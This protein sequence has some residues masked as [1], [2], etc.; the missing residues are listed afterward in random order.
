M[1]TSALNCILLVVT[2]VYVC[3]AHSHKE[4][5]TEFPEE[6]HVPQSLNAE[7]QTDDLKQMLPE[8]ATFSSSIL[9]DENELLTEGQDEGEDEIEANDQEWLLEK[10]LN[11]ELNTEG[12][13]EDENTIDANEQEWLL[14]KEL[15]DMLAAKEE[16]VN[17][18][19]SESM[20]DLNDSYF[21][22]Q[23]DIEENGG[24][25]D[26]L[27]SKVL[28]DAELLTEIEKDGS[29]CKSHNDIIKEKRKVLYNYLF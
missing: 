1:A 28:R 15:N 6:G 4:V 21:G 27:S 10:E 18:Y 25:N 8:T 12:W 22:E 7:Y 9:D 5:T 14:K 19:D 2:M 20:N 11:D 29:S 13:D 26:Q 24:K 16:N 3:I 23:P 17:Y